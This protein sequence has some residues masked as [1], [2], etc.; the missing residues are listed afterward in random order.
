M[1]SWILVAMELDTAEL[2]RLDNTPMTSP[3]YDDLIPECQKQ[4]RLVYK[5]I[6]NL[7]KAGAVGEGKIVINASGEATPEASSLTWEAPDFVAFNVAR[8]P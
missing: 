3:R 4:A 7:V 6:K 2:E 1:A 8:R 5:S